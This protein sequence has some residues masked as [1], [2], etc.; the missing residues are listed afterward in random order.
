MEPKALSIV[1]IWCYD[2][3][4]TVLAYSHG[5]EGSHIHAQLYLVQDPQE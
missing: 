2:Y 4:S 1:S 3:Y 5:H